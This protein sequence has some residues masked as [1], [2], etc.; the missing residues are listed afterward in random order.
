MFFS[1]VSFPLDGTEVVYAKTL[2]FNKENNV[3][4]LFEATGNDFI[5]KTEE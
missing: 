1:L 5:F 4:P 3:V 2:E